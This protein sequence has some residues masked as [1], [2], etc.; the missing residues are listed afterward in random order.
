MHFLSTPQR[1]LRFSEQHGSTNLVNGW[2]YSN[3][4][5]SSQS[6]SSAVQEWEEF[7]SLAEEQNNWAIKNCLIT[8]RKQKL[9]IVFGKPMENPWKAMETLVFVFKLLET[10]GTP[11]I[12][13]VCLKLWSQR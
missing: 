6:W 4:S 2:I 9:M 10:N 7:G 12:L 5:Y 1:F 13:C 11:S 8:L 3:W